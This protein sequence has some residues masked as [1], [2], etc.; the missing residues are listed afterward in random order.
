MFKKTSTKWIFI[1]SVIIGSQTAAI[2]LWESFPGE[3]FAENMVILFQAIAGWLM[4]SV[5]VFLMF[6]F[7]F[8][9]C[10]AFGRWIW[11][12]FYRTP[13]L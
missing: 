11:E 6:W 1:G 12:R 13:T 5:V 8:N 9:L 7:F 10:F 3:T 4:S 2:L